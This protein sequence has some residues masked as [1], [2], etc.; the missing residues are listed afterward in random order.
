MAAF[1]DEDLPESTSAGACH[2]ASFFL[3]SGDQRVALPCVETPYLFVSSQP[4][5]LMKASEAL[6]QGRMRA[7]KDARSKISSQQG[8]R[9]FKWGEENWST[10]QLLQGGAE[11]RDVSR[12]AFC[13]DSR[14]FSWVPVKRLISSCI[15]PPFIRN[16]KENSS[17][18]SN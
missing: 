17:A 6:L 3:A 16:G 18:C 14:I 8:K 13:P 7:L 12:A 15:P 5:L 9:A 11:R 10:E 2:Q 4:L 1:G